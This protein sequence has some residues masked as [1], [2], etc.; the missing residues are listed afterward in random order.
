MLCTINPLPTNVVYMRHGCAHFHR[1]IRSYMGV[2]ILGV[3]SDFLL[4]YY[5]NMQ[6]WLLKG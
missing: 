6:L 3:N 2:V 5:M 4:I 1:P